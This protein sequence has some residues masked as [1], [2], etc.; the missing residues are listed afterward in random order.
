MLWFRRSTRSRPSQPASARRPPNNLFCRREPARFCSGQVRPVVASL[1]AT[2]AQPRDV[3][4]S[5]R[6]ADANSRNKA[7]RFRLDQHR[8]AA[9]GGKRVDEGARDTA[10]RVGYEFVRTSPP[11]G[12]N[13]LEPGG[14]AADPQ[15]DAGQRVRQGL[16][17]GGMTSLYIGHVVPISAGST[18]DD[19]IE[20]ADLLAFNS[21]WMPA[22]KRRD[23]RPI[24]KSPPLLGDRSRAHAIGN[25]RRW[26]R[27][28][29]R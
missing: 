16:L 22:R 25:P 24:D 26:L 18:G 20:A 12:R 11:F 5:T 13:D 6:I 2:G 29:Y 23:A 15:A 1:A 17:L 3:L 21:K 4:R 7:R 9:G 27:R 10:R 28:R 19:Q 14:I 8:A